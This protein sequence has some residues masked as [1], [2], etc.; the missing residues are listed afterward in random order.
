M[1]GETVLPLAI[2]LEDRIALNIGRLVIANNR[3]QAVIDDLTAKL[4][5]LEKRNGKP[6]ESS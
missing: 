2:S 1:S 3:K 4:A 5:A 6:E